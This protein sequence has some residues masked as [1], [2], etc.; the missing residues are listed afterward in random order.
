[1]STADGGTALITATLH[2]FG[3]ISQRGGKQEDDPMMKI[4]S[5]RTLGHRARRGAT[6]LEYA[7]VL[8]FVAVGVVA[9]LNVL[10]GDVQGSITSVG[11]K[12]QAAPA[13]IK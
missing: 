2:R 11:Q 3:L 4:L 1:V 10:S 7:L 12:V 9:A 13:G 8:A 5:L 6:A